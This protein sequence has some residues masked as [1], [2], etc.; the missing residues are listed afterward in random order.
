MT[1]LPLSKKAKLIKGKTNLPLNKLKAKK[2]IIISKE[3]SD[4]IPYHSLKNSQQTR[5]KTK[6]T[7]I[8]FSLLFKVSLKF[9]LKVSLKFSLLFKVF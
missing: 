6:L 7:M 8:K 3:A 2:I 4:K 1:K 9:S 5:M